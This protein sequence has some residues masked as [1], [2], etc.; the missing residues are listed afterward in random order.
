[1]FRTDD[2]VA[3]YLRYDAEQE[4]K[5]DRLPVCVYCGEPIEAD[6]YFLINDEIICPDCL[7]SYFR[8]D[9]DEYID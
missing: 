3:D 2:P 8:K 4:A 9:I 7:E 6:H 1:M 5:R